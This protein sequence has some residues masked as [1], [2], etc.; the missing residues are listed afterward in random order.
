MIT[1][2]EKAAALIGGGAQ[3]AIILTPTRN[4]MLFFKNQKYRIGNCMPF[5]TT[6]DL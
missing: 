5:D 6:L 3:P 2:R 4:T 1:V